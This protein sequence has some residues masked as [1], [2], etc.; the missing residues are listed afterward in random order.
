MT[1][2]EKKLNK[3][4]DKWQTELAQ[5]ITSV[6]ELE[7]KICLSETEKTNIELITKIFKI[8]IT[9][10]YLSL[11]DKNNP[12]CPIRKQAIPSLEELDF[13]ME[14]LEDPLGDDRYSP[15][16]RLTH[17]YP[18]RVLIFPTYECATYCRHCFRRRIVGR[19]D[20]EMT[21]EEMKCILTYIQNHNEINEVIL[22]GGD[23]LLL[24][25]EVLKELLLKI[26]SIHHV[27]ILRIHTRLFVTL[28]HRITHELKSILK[29]AKPLYIVIH[30]NHFNEIS[31]QFRRAVRGIAEAGIPILSQSVLLKGINDDVQSLR[32][33]FSGLIE[34]SVKPY[35]LH[36][37]DLARGISHFRTPIQKGSELLKQLR[38]SVSGLC[39]PYYMVE[40]VG[41]HGKVPVLYNCFKVNPQLCWGTHRV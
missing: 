41:G 15:V 27:R 5:S 33:L 38:G 24:K 37:C 8:R 26:R 12:D 7:K 31:A 11:M 6:H 28:P 14:E 20:Q 19:N 18:D 34:A 32:K 30:V 10:F 40:S 23:P 2:R 39:I 21:K 1:S 17:R 36:Y 4:A 16:P 13:K 9:P 3:K 35:Y 29:K 22:T 25:D